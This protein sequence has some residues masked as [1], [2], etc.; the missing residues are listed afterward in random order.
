MKCNLSKVKDL[1]SIYV[2]TTMPVWFT[3]INYNIL[4]YDWLL[5]EFQVPIPHLSMNYYYVDI[6]PANIFVYGLD[7]EKHTLYERWRN[8]KI[9]LGDF[10]FSKDI[11]DGLDLTCRSVLGSPLYMSPE[12]M[13]H[14][15]Y[16][17]D[18]DIWSMACVIYEVS[19]HLF[20]FI[21]NYKNR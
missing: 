1:Q 21:I 19:V 4:V 7:E 18:S 15:Q 16:Y 17:F 11:T 12:R 2:Y 10:G 3:Y 20:I 5:S 13:L 9:K 14:Q 8:I 6:K